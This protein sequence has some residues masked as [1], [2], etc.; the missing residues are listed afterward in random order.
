MSNNKIDLAEENYKKS[1]KLLVRLTE[2][3]SVTQKAFE[4]YKKA[5]EKL[6]EKDKANK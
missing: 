4:E 2:T 3:L 6:K 1:E 5:S